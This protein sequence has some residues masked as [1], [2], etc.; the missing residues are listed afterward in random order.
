MTVEFPSTSSGD[1]KYLKVT[2]NFVPV[3]LKKRAQSA[4]TRYLLERLLCPPSNQKEGE[5]CNYYYR[6]YNTDN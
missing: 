1:S 2:L 5:Q 6:S 3:L 4:K